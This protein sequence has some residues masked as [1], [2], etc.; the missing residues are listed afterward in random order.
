MEASRSATPLI[1]IPFFFDQIRNSRAVEL[2]GWG[3][4]VSRFSLRDSPDDLR[5]ALHELLGD[6]R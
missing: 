5:R 2:N 6:P 4:P 1:S 3:I